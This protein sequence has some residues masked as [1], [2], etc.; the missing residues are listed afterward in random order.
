[1]VSTS[2]FH[3]GNQGS[4]PC[5]GIFDEEIGNQRDE[6]VQGAQDVHFFSFE[7]GLV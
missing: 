7:E 6:D 4:S 2:G 1:M 3:L 5:I